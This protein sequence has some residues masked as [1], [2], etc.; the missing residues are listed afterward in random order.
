M[1]LR[2]RAGGVIKSGEMDEK[3]STWFD[4]I[5]LLFCESGGFHSSGG[6]SMNGKAHGASFEIIA[7]N[8]PQNVFRNQL[9][10]FIGLCAFAHPKSL[11]ASRGLPTKK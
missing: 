2:G 6:K 7:V 8:S 11:H 9:L 5:P 4:P 10:G 1:A 3:V